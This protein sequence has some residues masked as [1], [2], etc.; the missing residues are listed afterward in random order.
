MNK[1]VNLDVFDTEFVDASNQNYLKSGPFENC[2]ADFC[3][4]A[5]VKALKIN[6]PYMQYPIIR[7]G[8]QR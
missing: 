2:L 6:L 5:L 4:S 7:N 8:D 1:F 3:T